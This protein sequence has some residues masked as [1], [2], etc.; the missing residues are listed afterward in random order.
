MTTKEAIR[1]TAEL[2]IEKKERP[3][4]TDIRLTLNDLVY[5]HNYAQGWAVRQVKARLRKYAEATR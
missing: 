3:S 2:F 1:Y 4:E 5:D